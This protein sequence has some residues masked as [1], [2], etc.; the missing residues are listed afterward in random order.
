MAEILSWPATELDPAQ[1]NARVNLACVVLMTGDSGGILEAPYRERE[2]EAMVD[3]LEKQLW[4]TGGRAS[5]REQRRRH[6][7]R[8]SNFWDL[9]D[10]G[11][12]D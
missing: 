5:V 12:G 4:E 2:R 10:D 9:A 11:G 1:L 3:T 8:I 7:R 6:A